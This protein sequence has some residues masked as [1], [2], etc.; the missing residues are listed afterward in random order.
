MFSRSPY[1]RHNR[2]RIPSSI[3]AASSAIPDAIAAINALGPAKFHYAGTDYLT[4]SGGLVSQWD[5]LSG[6]SN[7]STQ[8]TEDDKP[9]LV[10]DGDGTWLEWDKD[11]GTSGKALAMLRPLTGATACSVFTTTKR[12]TLAVAQTLWGFDNADFRSGWTSGNLFQVL[13]GGSGNFGTFAN[14]VTDAQILQID[15][16]GGGA[17]NADRLKIWR[18]QS[19][20]TLAFTGTIPAAIPALAAGNFGRNA[21][22]T[23][24]DGLSSLHVEFTRV[25][26][27]ADRAAFYAAADVL[28]SWAGALVN[29]GTDLTESETI[30]AV[31]GTAVDETATGVTLTPGTTTVVTDNGAPHVA[32]TGM[33]DDAGTIRL[34]Y[35][36][37][38]THGV[39]DNGAIQY[40]DSADEGDTWGAE[41]L[42]V[43][44]PGIDDRDA[45]CL[46]LDGLGAQHVAW[47]LHSGTARQAYTRPVAGGDVV[48]ISGFP[49]IPSANIHTARP[50]AYDDGDRFVLY[51]APLNGSQLYR[52]GLVDRGAGTLDWLKASGFNLYEP[53]ILRVDV[54]TLLIVVRVATQAAPTGHVEM[55]LT[56]STDNGVTWSDWKKFSE[57]GDAPTLFLHSTGTVFL[58]YRRRQGPGIGDTFSTGIMWSDDAG[59]TWG[60]ADDVYVHT[61]N[62]ASYPAI[63]ELA[64]GTLLISHYEPRFIRVT[65]VAVT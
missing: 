64:D 35:R 58:A 3:A 11:D 49:L 53:A 61:T 45:S 31:S 10:T 60:A 37:A 15:F 63:V 27:G 51:G 19:L 5:D 30:L 7:H 1:A 39:D 21:T 32:F 22:L 34:C 9:A 43:D 26:S 50:V 33:V 47:F 48:N 41:T 20:Q 18:N 36:K 62:D 8:A 23:P 55:M 52:V 46:F 65:R 40:K 14:S 44:T 16:D 17:A 38:S 2:G 29:P 56:R 24:Y 57:I 42:L 4:E 12:T 28:L 13:I 59:L 6:N 25:L 54:N